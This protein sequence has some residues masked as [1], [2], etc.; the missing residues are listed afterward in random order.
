MVGGAFQN[1]LLKG[2][3]A[4]SETQAQQMVN[5]TEAVPQAS[6]LGPP[7]AKPLPPSVPQQAVQG[8]AATQPHAGAT[9]EPA[10][11]VVQPPQSIVEHQQETKPLANPKPPS[12]PKPLADASQKAPA[13]SQ[14]VQAANLNHQTAVEKPAPPAVSIVQPAKDTA[15]LQPSKQV[16]A[17]QQQAAAPVQPQEAAQSKPVVAPSIAPTHRKPTPAVIHAQTKQQQQPTASVNKEPTRPRPTHRP[18]AATTLKANNKFG[19]QLATV[20]R[21]E[22]IHHVF[23]PTALLRRPTPPSSAKGQQSVMQH[24]PTRGKYR[25][26]EYVFSFHFILSSLF[27]FFILHVITL[28]I[29]YMFFRRPCWAAEKG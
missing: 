12:S 16:P 4:T 8:A 19:A 2:T 21:P 29:I 26:E 9:Q 15:S 7:L 6:N 28:R 13:Q 24:F 18:T 22:N 14:I 10:K 1:A 5:K 27:P 11:P 25:D 23:Q 3:K 17:A 20:T